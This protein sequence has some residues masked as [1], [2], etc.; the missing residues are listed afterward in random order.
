MVR[1][2]KHRAVFVTA[3]LAGALALVVSLTIAAAG[4]ASTEGSS[5]AAAIKVPNVPGA[6]A[7]K[8]KYGGTSITFFGDSAG[9]G[10]SHLRDVNLVK[11]FTKQTGVKVKLV[12]K[13]IDSTE[14]YAQLARTFSAKS[15]AYDV[16]MLDVVWPGSFAPYLVDLKPAL[17]KQAK[18]HSKGIVQGFTIKGQLVAMPWFSDYGILYYRTDLLRKYGYKAPPKTW[19]QLGAM[20]KKIQD[21]EQ[22]SNPNFYGFVYQGNAYEGLTCD[23]LEWLAS[24]GGGHFIDG[25]KVT[26]NNP[27]AAAIL[28]LQRSWVGS[29]TPRGV[30]TYTET[31]SNNAFDS[32]NA[33]FLRNWPYGYSTGQTSDIKGKF[34]VTVLPH[35]GNNPSVGTVGGWA[36][37]VSKYS[38]NQGAAIEFV[39]YLTSPG[40]ERYDAIF[41]SN[42]PTIPSI[43]KLPEVRKVNPWLKP[44]IAAVPRVTRPANFLG[45]KYQQGSKI[46]YQGVNQILNGQDAKSVLPRMQAQLTRLI[47]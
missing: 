5:A 8:A 3:G 26:I 28:N 12:Q 36:L 19:A 23:S 39:R 37:G 13:P 11:Q 38:K 16:M 25:G 35:S 42:V 20:A 14:D 44:E 4:S 34:D 30:T 17:G 40:V 32:G 9:A 1:K 21:G 7:I 29:I 33:A 27:R 46:I 18:L 24:S 43:A 15:S 10:K 41:S 47:R 6:Q 22:A 31:E 45:T 2:V